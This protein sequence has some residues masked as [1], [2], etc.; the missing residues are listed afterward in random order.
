MKRIAI[1]STSLALG[2][3]ALAGFQN[4]FVP[5]FRGQ[6]N[7]EYGAWESFTEP[8]ILPN[9]PDLP[10]ATTVDATLTQAIPGAFLVGGNIYSP[11]DA[12]EFALADTVPGRLAEVHLQ[13]S[14]KGA[15][16]DYANVRLNY[17]DGNGVA[18]SL[19]ADSQTQLFFQA[20]QGVDVETLFSWDLTGLGD[21]VM[22]YTIT[23]EAFEPSLSLDAVTLD[24]RYEDAPSTYCTAL[25]NSAGCT[26][27]IAFGGSG[28]ASTTNPTPFLLEATDVLEKKNGL[29][30]YGL[31]G[32]AA[33]PFQG[34]TLCVQP[35]LRRTDIQTSGTDGTI[36]GGLY[37]L[38]FNAWIQS[39][40]DPNLVVGAQVNA[41]YWSRDPQS[42]SGSGLTA[43]AEFTI[44]D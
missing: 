2:T 3:F 36:C 19:P 8:A 14:T 25:V 11:T 17:V 22:D 12:N 23:F 16:L 39:G 21:L 40:A 9:F 32:P 35:P 30:F 33:V 34:G 42:S 13:T 7:T 18:Q 1:L 29:L 24:T 44:L 43:G 10:G 4:P 20:S 6:P 28:H 37:S 27:Q 38:D 5:T 26:P 31:N 41:Q 15:E